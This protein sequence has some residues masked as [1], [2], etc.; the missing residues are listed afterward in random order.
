M[1]NTHLDLNRHCA[2]IPWSCLAVANEACGIF[3]F[4]A[5]LNLFTAIALLAYRFIR[6]FSE[7]IDK[8]FKDNFRVFLFRAFTKSKQDRS[9][10]Y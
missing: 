4:T 8:Q 6:M 2:D 1:H 5:T 3:M 10:L 7:R 9:I